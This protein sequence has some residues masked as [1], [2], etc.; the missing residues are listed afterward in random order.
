LEATDKGN[1]DWGNIKQSSPALKRRGEAFKKAWGPTLRNQGR[2]K[3]RLD[4]GE[5]GQMRAVHFPRGNSHE[6]GVAN[7]R[8]LSQTKEGRGGEGEMVSAHAQRLGKRENR[9][10]QGKKKDKG[11]HML[12]L[13]VVIGKAEN[14]DLKKNSKG[15]KVKVKRRQ[16]FLGI[17]RGA[18]KTIKRGAKRKPGRGQVSITR[19]P[20][21]A[22]EGCGGRVQRAKGSERAFL[23]L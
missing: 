19:D 15:G 7:K 20:R 4:R 16:R 9:Q 2:G 1:R 23:K 3:T 5:A 22:H 10:K 11:T 13:F 18:R 17:S 8:T 21:T 6:G 12:I 14:V